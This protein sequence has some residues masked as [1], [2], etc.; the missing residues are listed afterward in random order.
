ML[1]GYANDIIVVGNTP[2]RVIITAPEAEVYETNSPIIRTEY[3]DD[4]GNPQAQIH[5]KV[6]LADQVAVEEFNPDTATA[7]WDSGRLN[8]ADTDITIG[9]RLANFT[10]YFVYVKVWQVN[11]V[12]SL[13]TREQFSIRISPPGQPFVSPFFDSVNGNMILEIESRDNL[14]TAA[15]AS[16]ESTESGWNARLNIQAIDRTE[17]RS[18]EGALSWEVTPLGPGAIEVES[19]GLFLVEP[20]E[21]YTVMTSLSPG[22]LEATVEIGLLVEFSDGSIRKVAVPQAIIS[23]APDAPVEV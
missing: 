22:R 2:P 13:W 1:S 8:T 12:S 16:A 6:F 5:F 11:N 20:G 15:S 23:S 7:V 3:I 9:T 19:D 18:V 14:L 4:Q 17:A 21:V 10:D